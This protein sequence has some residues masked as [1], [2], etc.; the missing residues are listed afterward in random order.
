MLN[1]DAPAHAR[2]V[3]GQR[4]E[5]GG[6]QAVSSRRSTLAPTMHPAPARGLPPSTPPRATAKR[7]AV[8]GLV[9]PAPWSSGH[10]ALPTRVR[11]RNSLGVPSKTVPSMR[12]KDDESSLSGTSAKSIVWGCERARKKD[13]Q[14]KK[15]I[16]DHQAAL[17]HQETCLF[18][19]RTLTFHLHSCK[20]MATRAA[21]C[22]SWRGAEGAGRAW[23]GGN[24]TASP[25]LPHTSNRAAAGA[26]APCLRRNSRPWRLAASVPRQRR[27]R[28][29][30]EQLRVW[31]G[32]ASRGGRNNHTVGHWV[33]AGLPTGCQRRL[34]ASASRGQM[35][36]RGALVCAQVRCGHTARC[37]IVRGRSGTFGGSGFG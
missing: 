4:V 10:G 20:V 25:P 31:P 30:P 9:G 36:D 2:V 26:R 7:L 21:M 22:G 11:Q 5:R 16:P 34:H 17:D 19:P 13:P 18:K 33:G 32:A 24:A 8:P 35:T 28:R 29:A 3:R 15:A 6:A 14:K 27:P 1:P 12:V 23:G 37:G